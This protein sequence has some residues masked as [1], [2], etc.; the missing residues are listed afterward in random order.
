MTETIVAEFIIASS[1]GMKTRR[2]MASG[3][4]SPSAGAR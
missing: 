2:L 1:S 4:M 3:T